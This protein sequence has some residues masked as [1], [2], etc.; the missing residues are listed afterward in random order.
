MKIGKAIYDILTSNTP[1]S[2][3][4]STRIFPNVAPQ[5]TTMPFIIYQVV[6]TTPTDYKQ[7]VSSL[8]TTSIMVHAY[9]KTYTEAS[10]LAEYVRVALDRV[11]GTYNDIRVQSISFR[12]YHDLF[13]FDAGDSRSSEGLYRKA[14]DFDVRE[15]VDNFSNTYSLD[16]D[17]TDDYV[18][19]GD[20]AT[21]TFGNGT[22]DSAFSFSLWVKT[23]DVT[24]SGILAKSATGAKEY[25]FVIGAADAFRL[26]LYDESTDG[27]IQSQLDSAVTSWQGSWQHIVGTYDGSDVHTG[28]TL[29][30]NGAK[31][32]QT[33]SLNGSYT[34]MEDTASELRIGT[35]QQNAFYW[36]GNIDE[37]SLWDKELSSAEVTTLYNSGTPTNLTAQSNLVGWWRMGEGATYPT[38]PDDSPNSNSGT[39]TNMTSGDIVTTVP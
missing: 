11:S 10:Q 25:H 27:Y 22:T 6:S 37:V 18:T 26:R 4:V 23:A 35:S 33:T 12:S 21:F 9:S 2:D 38:I 3:L 36:G 28:I 20:S 19:L 39:M 5:T 7:G 16:F 30:V 13:D 34:A 24:S 32:A 31:P 14:L 15:I 29:Y 1:V 17:G 8:D